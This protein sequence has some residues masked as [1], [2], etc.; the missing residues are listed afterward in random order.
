M[1]IGLGH[2]IRRRRKKL[3]L[4]QA[5]LAE[6]IIS[7]P[8]LSLIENEKAHPKPDILNP[9]AKRL[10]TSQKELLGV[11]DRHVLRKAENLIDKVRNAL[12]YE[13]DQEAQSNLEELK[14]LA[15]LIAD[16]KVLIK[17]D[18]LEINCLIHFSEAT[19]EEKLKAFETKWEQLEDDANL[20]VW[21]LRIKGNILFMKDQ[22]DQALFY[23]KEAEK[24]IPQVTDELEKAYI[25]GNLGK[26]YLLSS[27]PSLGI[28]YTEKAIA[29]MMRKD[30]WMEMCSMLNI[31]GA[32]HTHKGDYK[33]AIAC[34]ERVLR[35]ADQFNF[36]KM[37]L[38]RTFHELGVCYLKLKDYNQAIA[39]LHRSLEV[40]QPEKLPDWEVGSVHRVLCQTYLATGKLNQAEEHITQ[41]ISLLKGR[42]R[43][44]TE[45]LIF[46]G[47]IHY[48]REN[49]AEFSQCY[50][51]A[52]DT[53][54]QLGT[55][56]KVAHAAH[57]LG[58]YYIHSGHREEGV[59]YLLLAVEYY[60]RLVPGYD[61]DVLFPEPL[62]LT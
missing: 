55:P 30:R 9:L 49:Y 11:T 17:T 3:G 16:P 25:Y 26:T 58:T 1:I 28:L 56:E 23:Y 19:Y 29:I 22:L 5:E 32:C 8:Y 7:V 34:F 35:I 12:V 20:M 38:S 36:S 15:D 48:L 47:Q 10:R 4:T 13:D 61:F 39:S 62:Q 44:K 53:F 21:Y 45:C 59:H 27:N 41:A 31:L 2:N 57:T 37:L 60:H 14:Q 46:L 6:G 33:D 18:L 51:E 24:V 40:V 43:M 52:I 54:L 42:E 50:Q